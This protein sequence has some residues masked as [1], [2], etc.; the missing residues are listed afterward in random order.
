MARQ[1]PPSAD[2]LH[3]LGVI[4][5]RGG[6]VQEASAHLAQA[7]GL[8]PDAP[9]ILFDAALVDGKLGRHDLALSRLDTFSIAFHDQSHL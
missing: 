8:A 1:L 9:G 3:L 2:V 4:M 5:M 7:L 6:R